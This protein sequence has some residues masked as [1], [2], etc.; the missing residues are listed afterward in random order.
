MSTPGPV[1]A[2]EGLALGIRA[3]LRFFFFTVLSDM[4]Q[5]Q[6]SLRFVSLLLVDTLTSCHTTTLHFCA[7]H[8]MITVDM[9]RSGPIRFAP[10]GRV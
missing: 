8:V 7:H 6:I 2:V 1:T 5:H 4:S 9:H 10:S 3:E